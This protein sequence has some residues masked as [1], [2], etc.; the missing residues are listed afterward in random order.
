MFMIRYTR[1]SRLL[2]ERIVSAQAVC[3]QRS[4]WLA[5][6]FSFIILYPLCSPGAFLCQGYNAFVAGD[7][8]LSYL[9]GIHSS[10]DVSITPEWLRVSVYSQLSCWMESLAIPFCSKYIFM[11]Y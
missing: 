1:S 9:P 11:W 8:D 6:G 7:L 10:S 4:V 5:L 3:M 2:L